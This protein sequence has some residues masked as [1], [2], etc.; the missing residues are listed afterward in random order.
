MSLL[1]ADECTGD[2]GTPPD[3]NLWG[4]RETDQWQPANELQ[5]YTRDLANAQ[6]DGRGNLII[7]AV[8]QTTGPR[9]YTS[10]KLSARHSVHRSL[11]QYGLFEARIKVP[12]GTGIFPAW[13]LLGQDDRYGWP[14]C[15]EI[16]IMEAPSSSSTSGQI[17]QG[18]HSPHAKDGSAVGVGVN[19]STG[20]W[21]TDF[22][23]YSINWTPRQIEFSIDHRL[24]GKVTRDDVESR[25][26]AW[27]FDHRPQSPILN[28]A[29]GGWA[30]IPD[31]SWSEQSM[32]IEWV[33]IYD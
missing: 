28:L 2:V 18:T 32:L 22:H 12:T 33:R 1:W 11:F 25:N 3:P 21:G 30:G 26:G 29:V 13:W 6:Y 31:G 14:H 19:P 9:P 7:K 5:T 4:I 10:A 16:D 8:K 27:P 15:G 23:T 17:H 24:T 20:N